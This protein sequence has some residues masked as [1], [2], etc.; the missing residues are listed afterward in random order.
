MKALRWYRLSQATQ[1]VEEKSYWQKKL[2][3]IITKLVTLSTSQ[4]LVQ[5]IYK[6]CTELAI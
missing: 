4:T 1:K 3:N 2:G 5:T 6:C